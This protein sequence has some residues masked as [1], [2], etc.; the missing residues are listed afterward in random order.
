MK[1][2]IN[3]L[4]IKQLTKTISEQEIKELDAW[5][6]LSTTNR[7]YYEH[8]MNDTDLADRFKAYKDIDEE[9]AWN[10]FQ[11]RCLPRKYS[12]VSHIM[13]YAAVL[14][15]PIIGIALWLSLSEDSDVK[16][17]LSQT[18]QTYMSKSKEMGKE[19]ATIILPNGKRV[20]V[21]GKANMQVQNISFTYMQ[22][23]VSTHAISVEQKNTVATN[24]GNEYWLNFNDGTIVHLNYNTTLM[25]PTHFSSEDRTVYLEGEAYFQVAKDKRPFRVVT[26]N[27][28]VKEYGT[29]FNV[30]TRKSGRTEVVLVEGSISV[31]PSSGQEQMMRPGD[32]ATVR[33]DSKVAISKIDVE[34]YIAWNSGHFIFDNY[35]LE[36]VMKVISL[37]YD[38]DVKFTSNDIK[39]VH[40]TGSI[41]K[42]GSIQPILN[43]IKTVTHLNINIQNKQIIISK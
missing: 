22:S 6:E 41:D 23:F 21:Q 5:V 15:I 17:V 34:P 2:E 31:T 43:A 9:K 3:E 8:I 42:Y 4:I 10:I 25:Y 33:S 13:K 40:Y 29:S 7:H 36:Q 14:M 16:P 12:L 20:G 32:L 19:K 28:V 11:K 18:T 38:L 24:N 37:W 27:S 1:D 30:N 35:T 39:N 26:A